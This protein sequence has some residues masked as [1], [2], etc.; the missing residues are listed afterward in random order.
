MNGLVLDRHV[1]KLYLQRLLAWDDGVGDPP[2]DPFDAVGATALLG[3]LNSIAPSDVG[4][5][6]LTLYQATL[7]AYRPELHSVF[8]DPQGA[9]FDRFQNWFLLEAAAGRIDPLL[10]PA[11]L[12]WFFAASGTGQL[13]AGLGSER[14]NCVPGM[15]VAGYLDA[16]H[17]IGE[18][19]RLA[20]TAVR[21]A[22]IPFQSVLYSPGKMSLEAGGSSV[23][24]SD[25]YDTNLVV[26]NA[27]QFAEFASIA[28]TGFFDGRYTI[29]QWAWELEE[30][31]AALAQRVR[32]GWTRFGRCRS[33]LDGRSRPPRTSPC[34][35]P[36]CRFSYPRSLPDAGRGDVGPARGPLRLSF[37]SRPSQRRRAQ[38]P[39]RRDRSLQACICTRRGPV[40]VIKTVNG[41]FAGDGSG[42]G[43]VRRDRPA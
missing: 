37:L 25:D 41:D 17:S 31:P 35:P 28:G 7:Y 27:D 40:L 2:P 5:S 8:P 39:G 13:A 36:H 15:T 6:R 32:A 33:S 43:A 24:P 9:D 18:S 23:P 29:A 11:R 3:W 10:V 30:F 38:E 14:T 34:S 26:V 12:S 20:T 21:A 1:R 16:S 42:D 4:P 19:A 22:R